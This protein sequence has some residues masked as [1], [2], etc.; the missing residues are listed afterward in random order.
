MRERFVRFGVI[1]F[2]RFGQYW[3]GLTQRFRAPSGYPV[4]PIKSIVDLLERLSFGSHYKPDPWK[5]KLDV[6]RHPRIVQK[7]IEQGKDIGDCDEHAGYEC[8]TLTRAKELAR[9]VWFCTIQMADLTT[10]KITGHAFAMFYPPGANTLPEWMDYG[11]PRQ[12]VSPENV[13]DEV[14]REYNA[15]PIAMTMIRIASVRK[16]DSLDFDYSSARL[17]LAKR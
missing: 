5:G 16:D 9:E 15:R 4:P 13:M 6:L 11:W 10:S 17:I 3:Y 14:A 1:L 7:W 8:N 12:C 2:W